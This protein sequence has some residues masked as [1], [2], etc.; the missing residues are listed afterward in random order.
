MLRLLFENAGSPVHRDTFLD[1][2]WGLDYFPESRTLDQH[3]AQLRRKIEADPAAPAIIETVRG[4]GYR[5]RPAALE[6]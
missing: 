4:V 6:G 5:Y 3:I 2:C 1:R